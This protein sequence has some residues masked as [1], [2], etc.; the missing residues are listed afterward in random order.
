MKTREIHHQQRDLSNQS[1]DVSHQTHG[2]IALKLV[3]LRP[4]KLVIRVVR[5][6][7]IHI[8]NWSWK[9]MN[10]NDIA[11]HAGFQ[12]FRDVYSKMKRKIWSRQW[13]AIQRC[14]RTTTSMKLLKNRIG[15]GNSVDFC[16]KSYLLHDMMTCHRGFPR[17]DPFFVCVVKK[18]GGWGLLQPKGPPPTSPARCIGFVFE[19]PDLALVTEPL[20]QQGPVE[21]LCGD[22]Y[23][24][25]GVFPSLGV[26]FFHGRAQKDIEDMIQPATVPGGTKETSLKSHNKDC[27]FWIVR[28]QNHLPN[29]KLSQYPHYISVISPFWLL[30]PPCSMHKCPW[31]WHPSAQLRY[32]ENGNLFDLL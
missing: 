32:L 14:C 12:G 16:G 20:R 29:E 4:R 22:S 1:A 19:T 13:T 24:R 9:S 27:G 30:K 17:S 2:T 28:V 6:C 15:R 23:K 7:C 5:L 10:I 11:L 18:N 31:R 21:R 26:L 8:L 3:E 25:Y